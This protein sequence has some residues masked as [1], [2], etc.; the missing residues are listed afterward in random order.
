MLDHIMLLFLMVFGPKVFGV[1]FD[2]RLNVRVYKDVEV[3]S[4]IV[5]QYQARWKACAC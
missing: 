4:R 1:D 5:A 3:L 2:R